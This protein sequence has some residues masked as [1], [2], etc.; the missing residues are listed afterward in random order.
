M[1]MVKQTPALASELA[2]LL[3]IVKEG[4]DYKLKG[5]LFD[6]RTGV[7][8]KTF[9]AKIGDSLRLPGNAV[10]TLS[11]VLL[12]HLDREGILKEEPVPGAESAAPAE[13]TTSTPKDVD[14]TFEEKP[15]LKPNPQFFEGTKISDIESEDSVT[16]DTKKA[17]AWTVLGILLLGGAVGGYFLY[18][19]IGSAE[20]S[21]FAPL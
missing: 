21:I 4:N 7:Y 10:D 14:T 15:Q 18:Q 3:A 6:Q 2:L 11:A 5:Q 9:K 13:T 20:V 12:S 1:E 8:T 17:V 19:N 16:Y